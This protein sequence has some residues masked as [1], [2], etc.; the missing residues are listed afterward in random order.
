M[1]KKIFALCVTVIFACGAAFAA[2]AANAEKLSVICSNFAEYDFVRQITGDLASVKMLLRPGMESHSFDPTVKDILDLQTCGLFVY[3]GGDSDAWVD[4]VLASFDKGKGPRVVK[5]MDLVETVPEEIVEGMQHDHDHDGD[6]D[7]GPD[8]DHGHDHDAKEEGHHHHHDGEE[9]ELDEHVWTAPENAIQIVK[10]LGEVAAELDPGNKAQY[11]SRAAVYL[12]QLRR[13]DDDFRKL[14]EGSKRREI[15]VGDRFPFLYFC[16]EFGL[17]YYAAFPGCAN[18]T[19]PNPE[20]VAFLIDKV[21]Q[22]GIPVVFHIELSNGQ[23]ARAIADATG[24]QVRLLN[25]VHNVSAEDFEKGITYLDLMRHNLNV[26]KEAL[27]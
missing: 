2:P 27:N 3:V 13:L 12:E 26:L 23:M 6:D 20:T 9:P 21:K 11:A 18:Q 4:K 22:D 19:E 16:R 8:C 15:I 7:H 25:A 17:K 1:K 10:K 24:A 5:L 14:I